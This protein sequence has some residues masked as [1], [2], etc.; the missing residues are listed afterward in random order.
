[1]SAVAV[2][3]LFICCALIIRALGTREQARARQIVVIDAY[4]A[5]R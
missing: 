3:V 5:R 1:M 4:R 2:V